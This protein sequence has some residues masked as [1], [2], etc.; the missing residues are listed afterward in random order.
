M[1]ETNIKKKNILRMSLLIVG[2]LVLIGGIS[3]AAYNWVYTGGTANTISTTGID[4][5]FLES[6]TEIINITNALP[7]YDDEGMNEPSFDFVVTS[8]T[9]R[10]VKIKY[11][12]NIEKLSLD[13]G[14]TALTDDEIK[15]YLTDYDNNPIVAP[16]LISNLTSYKLYTGTQTHNSSNETVQHKFK[17]R[18]WI[19]DSVMDAAQNWTTSTKLQYKFKIGISSNEYNPT[20]VYRWATNG[21]YIG[22]PSSN[23]TGGTSNP[24]T[25]NKQFYLKHTIE[26]NTVVESFAC[27]VLNN[28]EYCLKGG[29]GEAA[30]ADNVRVL[31]ESFGASNCNG[32]IPTSNSINNQRDELEPILLMHIPGYSCSSGSLSASANSNGRVVASVGVSDCGVSDDGYSGCGD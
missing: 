7:M 17:L 6:N 14:Y 25:L 27:Y 5:K 2:L 26:N 28:N 20:Y 13:S 30:Y 18:V 15:V 32:D 12:L 16:T 9:T 29:D 1:G 10:D 8:T 3:Y 4:L 21:V 11:T 22:D 23:I 19:D 31:Q 24:S